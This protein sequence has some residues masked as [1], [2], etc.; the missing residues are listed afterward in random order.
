MSVA[1]SALPLPPSLTGESPFWHPHEAA[2]YWCDV[3]GRRL[4]RHEPHSGRHQQWRFDT[5]LASCAPL[6]EGGLLL[7]MRDGLW[8]FDPHGGRR[9]HL[10]D[11]PYN[12]RLER[13]NDGKADPRGSFW[14]GTLYEPREPALAALYRWSDGALE[15]MAAGITNSNGLAWS[16]DG[17]RLYWADTTAHTVFVFDVD[18]I[19]GSLSNR[20]IFA[21]FPGKVAGQGL[22]DYGGRPD[23]AAVDAEGCYWV[24]MFEGQRVLRIAPDGRIVQVLELPVRCPTMVCFGG[25]DLRTLYITSSRDKRPPDELLQQPWAGQVLQLRVPV[26]GLP[27]N[28]AMLGA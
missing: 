11:P 14:V 13:F 22:D 25:A 16:P 10:S 17:R 26:P 4:N 6:L 7:A 23:G 5:E 28:F 15:R 12:P 24:A 20:R 21:Q 27:V 2:L 9:R 8:Q 18:A 3:P 1:I 19:D